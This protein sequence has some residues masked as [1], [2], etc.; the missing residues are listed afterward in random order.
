VPFTVVQTVG[1]LPR[2]DAERGAEL[3]ERACS[4]CHGALGDGA[5]ALS[6]RVPVLP[7][8]TLADHAD[9]TPAD[10][11]LVFVEKVRHGGFFGY[12]GVMPPFSLEV[13]SDAE[14]SDVLEALGAFGE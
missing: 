10:V 12:G 5:G 9:Y 13:L 7:D 4:G 2:G 8:A 1:P 11:R 3:F 14:L 6:P